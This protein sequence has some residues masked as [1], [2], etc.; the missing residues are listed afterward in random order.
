MF[1]LL[2]VAAL[3][4]AVTLA[5]AAPATAAD[6]DRPFR[7]VTAGV[8]AFGP[9]SCPGASW[10]YHHLGVGQMTH[11]GRVTV[12]V[13]HCTWLDPLGGPATFGPGTITLTAADGDTLILADWGTATLV[14]TPDGPMSVVDL[15][16]E[17]IGGTGRFANATGSG[18]G[19]PISLLHGDTGTTTAVYWG[20]IGY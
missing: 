9:P 4:A 17:V 20:S 2:G 16:W 1:K 7:G 15:E 14:I 12:E 5:G 11:L 10:Q 18:G 8:D 19:A 3:V 6:A 13:S